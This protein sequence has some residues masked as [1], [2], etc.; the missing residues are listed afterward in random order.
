[1]SKEV[2]ELKEFS[3]EGFV[4][5][6]KKYS[7]IGL[8][9]AVVI[10]GAVNKLT[11]AIATG[12]LTP[13]VSLLLPKDSFQNLSFTINGSI[14]QIGLVIDALLNFLIIAFVIYMAVK[15]LVKEDSDI[16]K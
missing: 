8:A 7:V 16:K 1:M 14:F 12:L 15:V 5:F 2:K 6:L 13:F 11:D 10:G 4:K 9:L 3:T